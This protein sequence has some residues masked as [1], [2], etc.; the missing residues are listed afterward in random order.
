MTLPGLPALNLHRFIGLFLG[1]ICHQLPQHSIFIGGLQLPLCARCMGTHLG[2]PLVLGNLWLRGRTRASRLPPVRVLAVLALFFLLWAL[3]SV[4]SYLYFATGRVMV[5]TPNNLLRLTTGMLNGVA[6][7]LLV[8]PMFHFTVWRE[9]G[10]ERPVNGIG[11]LA[12]ILL[13]VVILAIVL[14]ADVAPLMYPTLLLNLLSVLLML[15]TVNSM[16][17]LI[18]LRRENQADRWQQALKPLGLGLLLAI[19]EVGGIAALRY[20]LPVPL[21]SPFL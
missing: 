7:S 19:A 2:A 8:F 18:L 15:T 10:E 1:G 14:P 21:P 3:D 16:I 20:V 5:Y 13:Q 17:A 9:P 6:L 11:E 12:I 4:N